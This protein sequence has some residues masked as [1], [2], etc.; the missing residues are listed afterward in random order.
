MFQNL[1]LKTLIWLFSFVMMIIFY[2]VLVYK[3]Y[4]PNYL[5]YMFMEGEKKQ[6]KY[7]FMFFNIFLSYS[8]H[9]CPPA[10]TVSYFICVESLEAPI[11]FPLLVFFY[12]YFMHKSMHVC[13]K[14]WCS[15]VMYGW[16]GT[17]NFSFR[18]THTYT[19]YFLS[20]RYIPSLFHHHH[21]I[22]GIHV[23]AY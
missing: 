5:Y 15:M 20:F 13:S 18:N 17:F 1:A 10:F 14:F 7:I 6:M 23:Y 2:G 21:R 9:I 8:Y 12:I 4:K 3:S 22:R 16:L 11:F 19:Y